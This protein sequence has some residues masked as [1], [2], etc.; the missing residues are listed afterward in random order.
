MEYYKVNEAVDMKYADN[1]INSDRQDESIYN[2]AHKH[3]KGDNEY[4]LKGFRS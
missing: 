1:N 2:L 3:T 4:S